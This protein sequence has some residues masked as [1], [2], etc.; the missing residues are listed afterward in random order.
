M[1]EV[2]TGDEGRWVEVGRLEDLPTDRGVCVDGVAV[3]RINDEVVARRDACPHRGGSLAAGR[4]VDGV[5]TCPLHWWRFDL[6]TGHRLGAPDVELPGRRVRV[7]D[8]VVWVLVPPPPPKRS[9]REIL[10]DAAREGS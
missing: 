9:M 1:G 3:F 7:V 8:G 6:R 2:P 4:V 5:V 10:L